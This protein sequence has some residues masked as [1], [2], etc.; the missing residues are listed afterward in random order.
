MTFGQEQSVEING[1]KWM[2][3]VLTDQRR[4]PNLLV[5]SQV[6]QPHQDYSSLLHPEKPPTGVC[7][8][9]G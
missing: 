3:T 1:E 8:M 9:E 6:K 7:T 2:K 5:F 4:L